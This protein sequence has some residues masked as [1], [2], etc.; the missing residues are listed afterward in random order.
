MSSPL[1]V[2]S[3]YNYLPKKTRQVYLG[4]EGYLVIHN[5]HLGVFECEVLVSITGD[6][7]DILHLITNNIID[8][9]FG[10]E[11]ICDYDTEVDVTL[12]LILLIGML[13][14]R[15][16]KSPTATFCIQ[17]HSL[18]GVIILR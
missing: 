18:D 14:D 8:I 16:H 1:Y 5:D 15:R 9:R 7:H 10:D 6:N 3:L 12:H 17:P 11:A 2:N 13:E 4:Q